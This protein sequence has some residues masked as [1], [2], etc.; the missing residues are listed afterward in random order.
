V[1]PVPPDLNRAPEILE[2]RQPSVP[3]STCSAPSRFLSTLS[4]ALSYVETATPSTP[5]VPVSSHFRFAANYSSFRFRYATARFSGVSDF[6]GTTL[7]FVSDVFGF[8]IVVSEFFTSSRSTSPIFQTLFDAPGW[9][10]SHFS[11]SLQPPRP[12][13]KLPSHPSVQETHLTPTT[14]RVTS[15]R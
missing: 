8:F 15:S 5:F 10:L 2:T 12:P 6:I 7:E 9:A 13:S 4:Q 11:D 14:G 3:A 1:D